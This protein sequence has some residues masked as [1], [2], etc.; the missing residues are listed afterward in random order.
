MNLL[1][2]NACLA[3]YT[4]S[5]QFK[6]VGLAIYVF[7]YQFLVHDLCPVDLGHEFVVGCEFVAVQYNISLFK[8]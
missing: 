2:K 1:I 3:I 7:W 4:S 8:F 6:N 5:Y